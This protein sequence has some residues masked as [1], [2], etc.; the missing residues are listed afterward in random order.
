MADPNRG[1]E[2]KGVRKEME[3]RMKGKS[4][5]REEEERKKENSY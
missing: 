1:K 4:E 3:R 2:R 5:R